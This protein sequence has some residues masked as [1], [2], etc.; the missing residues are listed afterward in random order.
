MWYLVAEFLSYLQGQRIFFLR[1]DTSFC[2]SG[3]GLDRGFCEGL[4]LTGSEVEVKRRLKIDGDT[5]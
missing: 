3:L 2:S 4:S 1:S 5:S